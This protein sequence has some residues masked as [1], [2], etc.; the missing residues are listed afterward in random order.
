MTAEVSC[1][2]KT[3]SK[4]FIVKVPDMSYPYVKG[5]W[6]YTTKSGANTSYLMSDGIIYGVYIRALKSEPGTAVIV[7]YKD[8]K[9]V[10][11]I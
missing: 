5:E 2:E 10:L 4:N 7:L 11:R 6:L 8:G 3:V 9:A 1:G